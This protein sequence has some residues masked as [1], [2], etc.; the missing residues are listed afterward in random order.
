MGS[1]HARRLGKNAAVSHLRAS[2]ETAWWEKTVIS[3][4]QAHTAFPDIS[5]RG[6]ALGSHLHR[7]STMKVFPAVAQDLH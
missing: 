3:T 6:R 7:R 5:S 4:R 2:P 1:G